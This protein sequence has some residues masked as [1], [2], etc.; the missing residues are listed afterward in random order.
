MDDKSDVDQ[1][2]A[3]KQEM[4]ALEKSKFDSFVN[5]NI[6]RFRHLSVDPQSLFGQAKEAYDNTPSSFAA[7]C[8]RASIDPNELCSTL[9]SKADELKLNKAALADI[10]DKLLAIY[11]NIKAKKDSA[12]AAQ[13][14]EAQQK[15][16]PGAETIPQPP[17]DKR[18][19]G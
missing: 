6:F 12:E 7:Y 8:L 3:K 16:D 1:G 18:R 13:A 5:N 11:K 14:K 19:V 17:T 9:E 15:S 2:S 10:K 4:R